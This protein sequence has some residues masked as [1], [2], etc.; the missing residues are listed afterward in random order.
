M[1]LT[2]EQLAAGRAVKRALERAEA[3][4][5][6][7]LSLRQLHHRLAALRD[8]FR[9]DMPD[10]DFVSFGGGTPKTEDGTGGG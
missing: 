7:S 10:G 6:D 4:H 9:N 1:P 3:A 5:P 2:P 8:A